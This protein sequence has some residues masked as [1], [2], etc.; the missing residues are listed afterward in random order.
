MS[1]VVGEETKCLQLFYQIV[2][3]VLFE[4]TIFAGYDDV[5]ITALLPSSTVGAAHLDVVHV[6]RGDHCLNDVLYKIEHAG[7]FL[8]R[9]LLLELLEVF[10][11]DLLV[12]VEQICSFAHVIEALYSHAVKLVGFCWT[13][14]P[15]FTHFTS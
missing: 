10:E 1:E 14:A 9:Y 6:E 8:P 11:A 12:A 4:D 7:H 3:E 2:D 13:D 15:Y 5:N